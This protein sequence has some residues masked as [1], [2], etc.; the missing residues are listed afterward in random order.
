MFPA[1]DQSSSG[2]VWSGV[3]AVCGSGKFQSNNCSCLVLN[4]TNVPDVAACALAVLITCGDVTSEPGSGVCQT[5]W[6]RLS[7]T[8]APPTYDESCNTWGGWRSRQQDNP[9][10]INS[11]TLEW[12]QPGS[13]VERM[14]FHNKSHLILK[15][16]NK[17]GLDGEEAEVS[18]SDECFQRPTDQKHPQETPLTLSLQP[19][20]HSPFFG[21]EFRL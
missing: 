21:Q 19:R 13:L 15:W 11:Q 5:F 16:S 9:H 17:L 10:L 2:S 20:F 1:S 18:C 8:E 7:V 3:G 6:W 12:S 4:Q 14:H